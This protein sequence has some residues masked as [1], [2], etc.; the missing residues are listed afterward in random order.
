MITHVFPGIPFQPV[1]QNLRSSR[2]A[3]DVEKSNTTTLEGDMVLDTDAKGHPKY[4]VIYTE[5]LRLRTLRPSD[6]AALLPILLSREDV[7]KWTVSQKQ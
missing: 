6:A 3:F 7:M 1:T 2:V 4:H 5:R